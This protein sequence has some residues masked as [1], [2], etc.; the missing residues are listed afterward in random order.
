MKKIVTVGLMGIV[1]LICVSGV[2]GAITNVMNDSA[3]F[4]FTGYEG[5]PVPPSPITGDV[6]DWSV[7]TIA[8][9]DYYDITQDGTDGYI[10][11]SGYFDYTKGWTVEIRFKLVAMPAASSAAFQIC[12]GDGNHF[13][14][15]VY[16][17]G[18]RLESHYGSGDYSVNLDDGNFHVLR[19]AMDTN[20]V[21]QQAYLDGYKIGLTLTS[22]YNGLSRQ[23]LGDVGDKIGVSNRVQIDYFRLDNTGAL[24]LTPKTEKDSADF[25]CKLYEGSPVPPS[26]FTDD[27]SDW[28]VTNIAGN[29]YYDIIQ[30]DTNG[31]ISKSGYFDNIKGWTA[32]L[33]F[34]VV[35]TPDSTSPTILWW[36]SDNSFY[37]VLKIF[38]D[39]LY[40][41]Y[42][43]ST[44]AVDLTD[45][46][47]VL[48]VAMETNAVSNKVYLDGK[49]IN[50]TLVDGYNGRNWQYLGDYGALG[51]GNHILVDYL[52]LDNAGPWEPVSPP[53]GTVIIV[54]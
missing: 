24:A 18:D 40:A 23:W 14:D 47:H 1:L 21:G 11:K 36:L 16:I 13:Y 43:H 27:S 26:P 37:E 52:R 34:K 33:R 6:S 30:D 50:L 28:S 46:F 9:N 29:D 8:G 25:S 19:I 17:Y 32:E 2:N 51:V 38:G 10:S 42:G 44:Y 5:S 39:K 31:Y 22:G 7:T 3:G 4:S 45:K 54:K 15:V 35:N 12:L 48:R 53:A 20:T 41:N 49:E